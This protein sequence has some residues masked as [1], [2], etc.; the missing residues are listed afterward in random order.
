MGRSRFICI[1][2]CLDLKSDVAETLSMERP[3]DVVSTCM[4]TEGWS[5]SPTTACMK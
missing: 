4:R 2:C 1:S 5:N 3:C